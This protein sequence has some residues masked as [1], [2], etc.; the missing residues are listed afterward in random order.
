MTAWK[1]KDQNQVDNLLKVDGLAMAKDGVVD[2][3]M[4]VE[5]NV[6]Y[7]AVTLELDSHCKR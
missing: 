4:Q 7:L 5:L 6:R 3:V 1:S 2:G